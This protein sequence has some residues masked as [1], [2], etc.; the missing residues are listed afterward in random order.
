MQNMAF[1]HCC[2]VSFCKQ[3]QRNE[4]RIIIHVYTAIALVIVAVKLCL[5]NEHK[6]NESPAEQK[7][8]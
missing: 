3:R 4:Q 6:T 5:R 2:I 1:S 7:D 8:S